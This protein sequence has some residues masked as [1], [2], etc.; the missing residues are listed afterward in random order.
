MIVFNINV[1]YIV[2]CR[3]TDFTVPAGI[4]WK[5]LFKECQDELW[6]QMNCHGPEPTVEKNIEESVMKTRLSDVRRRSTRRRG[7]EDEAVY[8]TTN[9][10]HVNCNDIKKLQDYLTQVCNALCAAYN[11]T[12]CFCQKAQVK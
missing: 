10:Q 7:I 11:Q 8:A 1:T 6:G 3:V 9:K 12:S 4:K 5:S 2:L